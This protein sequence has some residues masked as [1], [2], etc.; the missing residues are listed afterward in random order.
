MEPFNAGW[1]SIVPPIVAIALALIT[2]EVLSSLVLG[3]LTGTLIY[4]IGMDGNVLMGTLESAFTVM[5]NKVINSVRHSMG[6][7]RLAGEG[8]IYMTRG[9]LARLAPLTFAAPV[10]YHL[11]ITFFILYKDAF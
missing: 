8:D 2:K 9:T 10:F 5:G 4:T 11:T 7:T 3:I 6:A 1:L